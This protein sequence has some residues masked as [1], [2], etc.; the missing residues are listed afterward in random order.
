MRTSI[1]ISYAREDE[2]LCN[3]LEKH[4]SHLKQR[5]L[6]SEWQ[7]QNIKAGDDH[8][9]RQGMAPDAPQMVTHF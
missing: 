1:F 6:I 7:V 2:E 3:E 9:S 8:S 5:N 4:L